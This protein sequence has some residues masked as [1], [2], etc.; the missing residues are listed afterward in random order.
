[1]PPIPR[2]QKSK[3]E[4][5]VK[6]VMVAWNEFETGF[7]RSK[8]GN[9]WQQRDGASLTVFERADGWYGWCVAGPEGD[10]RFSS[11]AYETEDEA[12]GA[13]FDEVR[14]F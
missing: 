14:E 11:S 12:M 4:L 13:L 10:K 3:R 5:E 2:R 9:L 8:R 6:A 7:R 1:M